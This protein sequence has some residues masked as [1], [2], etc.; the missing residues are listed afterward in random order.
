MYAREGRQK[1]PYAQADGRRRSAFLC[2]SKLYL[3]GY[4]LACLCCTAAE[5]I[6]VPTNLSE[7]DALPISSTSY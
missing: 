5:D 7:L 4:T 3:L 6:R 1:R 2:V